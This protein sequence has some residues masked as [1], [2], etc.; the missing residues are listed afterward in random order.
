MTE[1][2]AIITG[3]SDRIGAEICR[4]L[5][6]DGMNIVIH[7]HSSYDAANALL[8][9]LNDLRPG[10]AHLLNGDLAKIKS[11]I[12]LIER[13]FHINQ[14][15][16]LLVNN[17]SVFYPTP[18]EEISE[19]K[20]DE[21]TGI[22]LRAPL[23][24]ARA[25]APYLE[26][27]RGCII[28]LIDIYAERPLKDHTLYCISKAGLIMLTKTLARELGPDI[29]VNAI[30]PGAILWPDTIA[31]DDKKEILSRT[32]LKR[33]GQPADIARAVRY[34]FRDADYTTGQILVIDGGRSLMP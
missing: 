21:L 34:L 29:R 15:L 16:D 20:W 5:H 23:F 26:K 17:A 9:E 31:E 13:A 14:R 8:N 27:N 4:E 12:S 1:S 33:Q 10:S 28:N 32:V 18:I 19:E 3:G 24:L 22:N 6:R 2:T 11:C 25:A 30:S 7:Y